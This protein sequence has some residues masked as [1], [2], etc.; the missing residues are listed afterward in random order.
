MRSKLT[1]KISRQPLEVAHHSIEDQTS[2]TSWFEAWDNLFVPV[3]SNSA[4]IS[5]KY[6]IFEKIITDIE[7]Q[8]TK[9]E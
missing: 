9:N 8:V 7:N 3:R 4:S 1:T 5:S 2:D 6:F